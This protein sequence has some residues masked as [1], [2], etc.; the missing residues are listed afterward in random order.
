MENFVNLDHVYIPSFNKI[1]E[2]IKVKPDNSELLSLTEDIVSAPNYYTLYPTSDAEL[3]K[4]RA[5]EALASYKDVLEDWVEG[6]ISD[7]TETLPWVTGAVEEDEGSTNWS[8]GS[9]GAI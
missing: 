8:P 7:S 4:R 6:G 3:A 9:G 1:L 5:A 2:L